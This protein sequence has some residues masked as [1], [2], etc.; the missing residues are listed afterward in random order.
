MKRTTSRTPRMRFLRKPNPGLLLILLLAS[1]AMITVTC[2]N[3]V[4][5]E[6]LNAAAGAATDEGQGGS[7]DTD[8]GGGDGT[9]PPALA[10][11][12]VSAVIVKNATIDFEG[13]GGEPDYI[14]SIASGD[15]SIE[16]DTGIYTA[17]DAAGSAVVQVTDAS[18]STAEAS[19]TI[20]DSGGGSTLQISPV[21]VSVETD[22][23]IDFAA[24]GGDPEYVFSVVGGGG[25]IEADTGLYTAPATAGSATVRVE[26]SEGAFAD[27]EVTIIDAAPPPLAIVPA[28]AAVKITQTIAFAASGGQ[29]GYVFSVNS[30][31]GVVD[32]V[33]GLYTAP[34]TAGNATVRIT[35]AG[36]ATADATV[37]IL[38]PAELRIFPET[39]TLNY[40]GT[41]T[42]VATGGTT[43]Y[44]FGLQNNQSGAS[45]AGADYTAGNNQG[46]DI[47]R[48]EDV[49]GSQAFASI[50]VVPT[51][52]LVINPTN[53]RVEEGGTL[54]FSG[55]GG[56]PPYEFS[57][58]SGSG[59]ILTTT[60]E[61]TASTT[62]GID[63]SEVEITDN[64]LDSETTLV[65]VV[66][67]AP[68]NL[69]ADGSAGGPTELE[70]TW[71]DN[72]ASEDGYRIERRTN[73][74]AYVQIADVPADSTSYPDGGLSPNTLYI[75][76]VYAYT[77][78]PLQSDYS[79]EG[80]DLP[81][82]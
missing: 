70:L 22:Q 2:D 41:Y 74:G 45:M 42:F 57:I 72:S 33:S 62:V 81:N 6:E 52:V 30:G 18:G 21:S 64:V 76:R 73:V 36:G 49:G 82:S 54:Q 44:T 1:L 78:D 75:Y 61:Y 7:D 15:G 67:K 58:V 47:V 50:N 32:P 12:P 16:A 13:T 27:A 39:V 38:V 31:G 24:S 59:S 26:D 63:V 20:L 28:T 65:D 69:I 37:N 79:N 14:F 35:D 4:L 11:S 10:I 60:G 53:P 40:G 34:A 19:V 46:T 71:T 77:S 55:A 56:T 5:Y 8:D 43:P 17:P 23:T 48:V 51:G 66:P 68:T 80:F 3:F 9:A 25:S 29:G